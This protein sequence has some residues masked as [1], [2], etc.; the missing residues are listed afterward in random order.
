VTGPTPGVFLF[1]D[2]VGSTRLW[3]EQPDRM[4]VD[5]AVH[6]DVSRSVF[7]EHGGRV[8]SNAGDS[9]GVAFST[10]DAAVDAAVCLQQ[11]IGAHPWTVDGGIAVRIGIHMGPAQER[12]QNFFGPAL[13]EAA[14]IMSVSHG[15]QIVVSDE[16][17]GSV[18]HSMRS[19]G[20]HRLRDL[21][22]RW[23]LHQVDV[24]GFENDHEPLASL[25]DFRSTLPQQRTRLIGREDDVDLVRDAIHSKRLVTLLG[26]GG[27]GKTRV[28]IE[29]AQRSRAWFPGGT[30]F[31]DLTKVADDGSVLPAFVDGVARA[32]LPE[33][34]PE[35]HVFAE[36]VGAPALVVV[37]NCEHVIE[38]VAEFIDQLLVEVANVSVLAT[39]RVVLDVDDEHV[40]HLPPLKTDSRS[41][42]AVELFVERALAVDNTLEFDDA[43]LT[44]ITAIVTRLDGLPLAIELAAARVRTLT[45]AQIL[46]NLDERFRLLVG[47][48]RR[49]PRQQSLESA[50]A[51]SYDLLDPDEQHAL[52]TLA[53]CAGPVTLDTAARLLG[54][55]ALAA[56]DRLDSLV[57]K[58]L[59]HVVAGGRTTRGFRML[60]SMR[61]FGRQQLE[62]CGELEAAQLA[63]ESALVPDHE[64]IARDYLAFSDVYCDWNERIALEATTRRSAASIAHR[65]GRI[66]SAAFIYA[67]ATSPDEPGAHHQLLAEVQE[68]RSHD[69]DLS[70]AGRTASW[71]AQMWLQAFTFQM[72]DMLQTAIDALAD[73]PEDDPSRRL[74]DAYRLIALTVVDPD[75]VIVATAGLIPV[76]LET[77]DR[78]HDYAIAFIVLA[79]S[80]ALLSV[81]DVAGAHEAARLALRWAA[82]GSGGYDTVLSHLLWMEYTEG[83]TRGP[84]LTEARSLG[85]SHYS[86]LRVGVAAAVAMDAPIE[87][88]A[89]EVVELARWHALGSQIYEESLFIVAFAWLAL[90]EQRFDRAAQL[91]TA[92]AT[93]DPGSGTAGVRALGRLALAETGE[94]VG[95]DE[96]LLRFVDP[97]AHER[98]AHSVPLT[99]SKELAYWDERLRASSMSADR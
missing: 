98:L 74:F 48:R 68:L 53:M 92:F 52:R 4:R 38:E 44:A 50:I 64:E 89:G 17:A 6:D 95:R 96:M 14:R 45:P 34:C 99:L 55:D 9:F 42:A 81:N 2:I 35:R 15:G 13:N 86:Q 97:S 94:S 61:A 19:L 76:L 30:F 22:G 79:R 25:G 90:E 5:L 1:T 56:A 36:L 33:R 32:V 70:R 10:P 20:E 72:G 40:V 26:P 46:S 58:S 21:D 69:A 80:V 77:I 37:D 12:N 43:E 49:D 8:F 31:V 67:S 84:E 18:A 82:P 83:L 59:I 63:L 65:A 57:G 7:A 71:A 28:A 3:A 60:E 51:W 88:R 91:L 24:R 47:L 39:S 73:L 85:V 87:R 62:R 11:L 16:V 23:S 93:I 54:L 66:E 75:S 27:A 78:S 41:S 29:V